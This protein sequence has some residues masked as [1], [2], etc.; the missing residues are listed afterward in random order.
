MRFFAK[1][2]ELRVTMSIGSR[3]VVDGHLLAVPPKI[4]QFKNGFYQTEDEEEIKFLVDYESKQPIKHYWSIDEAQIN[5]AKKLKDKIAEITKEMN[6]DEETQAF[7]AQG[8]GGK[9]SA[10]RGTV[11]SDKATQ[12]EKKAKAPAKKVEVKKEVKEEDV[13]E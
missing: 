4:I 5:K 13:K 8:E 11:S 12:S 10:V 9:K 2:L 6:V 1:I 7:V 3:S